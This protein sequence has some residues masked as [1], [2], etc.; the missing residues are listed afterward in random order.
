[1]QDKNDRVERVVKAIEDVPFE[2][3]VG[4][5]STVLAFLFTE[6]TDDPYASFQQWA[7]GL[8]SQIRAIA[9]R[10]LH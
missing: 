1:M 2:Y 5:I 6:F 10:S 7:Q 9:E 8:G 3:A 4:S